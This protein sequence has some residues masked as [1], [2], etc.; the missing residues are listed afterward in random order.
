[1]G[2]LQVGSLQRPVE[3]R[4]LRARQPGLASAARPPGYPAP[5]LRLRARTTASPR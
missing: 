5:C 2:P 1:M 4:A 3:L